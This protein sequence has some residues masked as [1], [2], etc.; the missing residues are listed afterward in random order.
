M[1]WEVRK[2][3]KKKHVWEKKQY[4]H[5]SAHKT[6]N[7]KSSYKLSQEQEDNEIWILSYNWNCYK[8]LWTS[9]KEKKKQ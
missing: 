2:N 4:F 9:K 6:E 8:K 7:E 3:K 5:C 1:N